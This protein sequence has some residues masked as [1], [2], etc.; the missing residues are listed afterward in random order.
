MPRVRA[1]R[2]DAVLSLI[3]SN[4]PTTVTTLAS[5]RVEVTGAVSDQDLAAR[6]AT[7]RVAACPLRYGA[8]VKLKVLEAMHHGVPLVT[9]PTGAQ[10]LPGLGDIC[11]VHDEAEAFALA[12][13]A[14]MQDDTAWS[15]CAQAQT[16]YVADFLSLDRL[17][18]ALD[19]ALAP[20]R[21]AE[22]RDA[23]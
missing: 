23:A 2:P 12:V 10:G 19:D 6:Y 4:P 3:G 17:A 18:A 20:V 9:T 1:V 7:A 22:R 15:A 21:S 8:G 5:D 14:L 13:L 11:A 16:Q